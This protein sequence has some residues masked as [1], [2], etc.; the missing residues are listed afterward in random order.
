MIRKVFYILALA[1]TIL[2]S[3]CEK[4]DIDIAEIKDRLG[5]IEGTVITNIEQQIGKVHISIDELKTVNKS[6]KELM[7]NLTSKAN[8]LQEELDKNTAAD[9]TTKKALQDEIANIKSLLVS[10]I[11]KDTKLENKIANLEN[12]ITTEITSVK[13]WTKATFATLAQYS[14]METE[15]TNLKATIERHKS[16]ITAAYT[17]AIEKAIDASESSMKEWVNKTLAEG[18]YDIATIDAKLSTLENKQINAN[19]ELKKQIEDQKAAL[20]QAKKELT[21]SYEEAIAEAIETNNGTINKK[22]AESIQDAMDKVDNKLAVIDNTIA[23]IQKDIENIKSEISTINEQITNINGSI[24]ELEKAK[25]ELENYIKELKSTSAELSSKIEQTNEKINDLAKGLGDEIS[26]LEQNLLNQ[27]N[28]LK[29][30]T[31]EA[32]ANINA[33][34]DKLETKNAEL[35]KKIKELRD[36][37][38][39]QLQDTKDWVEGTFAT[40]EQQKIIQSELAAISIMIAETEKKLSDLEMRINEK[41]TKDINDAIEALRNELNTDHAKDIENVVKEITTSYTTAIATLKEEITAEYTAAI[42]NILNSIVNIE[43]WI[44]NEINSI[45]SSINQTNETITILYKLIQDL[46]EKIDAIDAETSERLSAKVAIQEKALADAITRF[47]NEYKNAIAEAINE[48]NGVINEAIKQHLKESFDILQESIYDIYSKIRVLEIELEELKENFANR[49]Q[50]LRFLPQYNDGKVMIDYNSKCTTL[51]FVVSP[52]YLST[53]TKEAFDKNHNVIKAYAYYTKDSSTRSTID[54]I[55]M[56]V[57]AMTTGENGYFTLIIKDNNRLN[58][59]FWNG[60]IEAVIYICISD[61]NN[62]VISEI[63]PMVAGRE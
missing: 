58:D 3:G 38:D 45:Y 26:T 12:Y 56:Q 29:T 46:N 61:G 18:Y 40:L 7:A 21:A 41:I 37:V 24:D 20:E 4:Y 17:K 15:I 9:A 62:D 6:L 50:S 33:E 14:E 43:S 44:T 39:N 1:T 10:L 60:E 16:E 22:I 47:E 19:K 63:I 54:L 55:E 23:A 52:A 2:L 5:L 35:E 27:L 25:Q 28:N 48:N 51:D 30:T 36:Y 53:R 32:L 59:K 57:I 11:A 49:I 13:D 42:N 8:K 34:I 31:E